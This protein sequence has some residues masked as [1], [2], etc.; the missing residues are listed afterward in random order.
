M[1]DDASYPGLEDSWF[2]GPTRRALTRAQVMA[3]LQRPTAA[4]GRP[5]VEGEELADSW[6]DRPPRV[7]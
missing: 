1:T 5:E 4:T 6:F 3:E 2:D 7:R